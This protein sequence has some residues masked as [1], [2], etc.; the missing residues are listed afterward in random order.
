MHDRDSRHG[1]PF[2][3]RLR[4]LRANAISERW[5]RSVRT[6]RLDH[7]LVFNEAHLRRAISG[8]AAYFNYWRPHRSLGQRAPCESTVHQFRPRG[9]NCEITAEPVLG[10]LHHIYGALPD[11]LYFCALQPIFAY[12]GTRQRP[13]RALIADRPKSSLPWI[14]IISSSA[15]SFT[16]P[17]KQLALQPPEPKTSCGQPTKWTFRQTTCC[18]SHFG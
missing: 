17:L 5:V 2:D 6:E 12:A 18:R 15:K 13:T 16:K 3:R 4:R 14:N 10:G 11:G 7:L 9:A 1:A 8:Y